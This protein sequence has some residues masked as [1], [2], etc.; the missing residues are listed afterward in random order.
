MRQWLPFRANGA[1]TAD[2][3]PLARPGA[4][5]LV[6]PSQSKWREDAKNLVKKKQANLDRFSDR[7]APL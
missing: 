1:R 3:T 5:A 4:E 7:N 2:R 6:H